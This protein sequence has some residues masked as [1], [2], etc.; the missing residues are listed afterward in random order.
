MP[1]HRRTT[2]RRAL[3]W[4]LTQWELEEPGKGHGDQAAAVRQEL[5]LQPR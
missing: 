1:A 4:V 2:A 5:G 3:L